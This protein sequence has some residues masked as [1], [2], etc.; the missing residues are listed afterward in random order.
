MRGKHL[1]GRIRHEPKR[2]TTKKPAGASA[3]TTAAVR[4]PPP[5]PAVKPP[6]KAPAVKAQAK[7]PAKEAPAKTRRNSREAML[8]RVE[9]V[10]MKQREEGNFDCFGRAEQGFC[11]QGECAYHAECLSVSRL[12]HSL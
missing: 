4:K 2:K 1:T 6:A 3:P 9:Q 10:R 11:D 7:P 12:L 5:T 8:G